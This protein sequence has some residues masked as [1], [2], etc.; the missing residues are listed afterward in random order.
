MSKLGTE[1]KNIVDDTTNMVNNLISNVSATVDGVNNISALTEECNAS[2]DIIVD[3]MTSL[4]A[5]SE[6][7]AASTEETGAT[8]Q[9]LNATVNG[10]AS[11]AE[12]LN[13]IAEQLKNDLGFFQ[14]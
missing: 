1:V 5:I 10:I 11:S 14:T 12:S 3:A 9:E 6:K 4:S 2:K 13:N 8:M 7:N